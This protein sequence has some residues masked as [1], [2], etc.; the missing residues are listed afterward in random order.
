[1]AYLRLRGYLNYS[2]HF[3]VVTTFV[4]LILYAANYISVV[5]TL[6]NH[7]SLNNLYGYFGFS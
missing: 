7:E 6:T 4:S 1:M 5:H 2:K 3:L